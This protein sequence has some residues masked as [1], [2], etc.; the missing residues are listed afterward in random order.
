MVEYR[1]PS[2]REVVLG[3][4]VTLWLAVLVLGFVA[5][6]TELFGASNGSLALLLL[7]VAGLGFI[8]LGCAGI[9][10]VVHE[11]HEHADGNRPT[12]RRGA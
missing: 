2:R 12:Q 5:Q 8:V 10:L 4:L 11:L 9:W 1:R 7:G 6:T 3:G